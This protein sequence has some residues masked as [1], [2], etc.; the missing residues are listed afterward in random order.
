[1]WLDTAALGPDAH[2]ALVHG[3]FCNV[4]EA[5]V[6]AAIVRTLVALGL[7]CDEIGVTS[8]YRQQVAALTRGIAAALPG[9]VRCL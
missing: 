2:E 6:A 1:M 8:P 5:R 7:P 4:A 9:Q 3:S